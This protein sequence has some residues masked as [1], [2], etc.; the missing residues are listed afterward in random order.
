MPDFIRFNNNNFYYFAKDAE[1]LGFPQT[2]PSYIPNEYLNNQQFFLWRHCNGLGDWGII[3]ALPRLLKQKYP[4]CKVYLP[5]EK[6]LLRVWGEKFWTHWPNPEQNCYRIFKNNPYVDEYI[7]NVSG[8][9]F[10][11]H[12]RI[13][14]DKGPQ[15]SL[16]KQ[17]LLFWQF[18][19][20]EITDYYPELYFTEEEINEG[21]QI[22]K[23]YFGNKKFGGFIS[24]T[25]KL[26]P[27]E[28]FEDNQNH[29][30]IKALQQYSSIPFVYY[31]KTNI[32]NTPFANY[33]KVGLDL[34]EL[35]LPLR[36][37]L[38]IRSKALVNIGYQSSM[39]D[40]ICRYSKILCT[41]ME[42]EDGINKFDCISYL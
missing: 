18:S 4:N 17:I 2:N 27:G 6:M 36:T 34:S 23:E 24:T 25:S 8:E 1:Y 22:I 38:Y 41:E 40:I 16:I 5:S 32:K 13:F 9:V 14:S 37:Q 10:H 21:N 12:Y 30:L 11:D 39:F 31:G 28:F 15:S 7:D 3:S 35:N 29:K 20:N 33:I 26:K 42:G 19:E